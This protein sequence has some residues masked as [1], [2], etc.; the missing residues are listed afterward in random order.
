[1]TVEITASDASVL[2][3]GI[4]LILPAVA[5]YLT[6]LVELHEDV[7]RVRGLSPDPDSPAFEGL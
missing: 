6:V 3:Q 7:V 5:L 2:Q 4:A 1:M